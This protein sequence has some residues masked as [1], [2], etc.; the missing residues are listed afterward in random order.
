VEGLSLSLSHTQDMA[1]TGKVLVGDRKGLLWPRN[2]AKTAVSD[3][4]KEY[5]CWDIIDDS[6]ADIIICAKCFRRVE[7]VVI[8]SAQVFQSSTC[9]H[10]HLYHEDCYRSS[11]HQEC[12]Y[13]RKEVMIHGEAGE[14]SIAL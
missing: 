11:G 7:M 13:C 1:T 10:H 8:K 12:Q 4:L 6:T 2:R 14:S 9:L 3:T 5:N